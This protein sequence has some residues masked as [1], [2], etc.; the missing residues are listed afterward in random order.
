MTIVV[1]TA[2][3]DFIAMRNGLLPFT[4]LVKSPEY[5]HT[6]R[7]TPVSVWNAGAVGLNADQVLSFLES[8]AR[9]GIPQ[10]FRVEVTTWFYRS[11]V[12]C[13]VAD[14][15]NQ[16]L[17]RLETAEPKVLSELSHDPDLVCHF[18]SYERGA[19]SATVTKARRGLV[20]E[21]LMKLG[22]PVRD[23]AGYVEGSALDIKVRTTMANGEA[24]AL[25]PYQIE[26]VESFHQGGRADG[27]SVVV[28]GKP[29]LA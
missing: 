13:L 20:K 3:P 4:E 22:Y 1:E 19:S 14:E 9:Y 5:L 18:D 15:D 6:Y 8:H 26:A 28:Q 2:H 10:N 23:L 29:L 16:D 11:E 27:G 24:F 7:I 21:R 17:L 25:R 12:F